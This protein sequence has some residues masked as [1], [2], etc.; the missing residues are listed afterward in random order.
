M[1]VCHGGI[2]HWLDQGDGIDLWGC[3]MGVRDWIGAMELISGGVP[4]ELY[5]SWIWAVGLI[6]GACD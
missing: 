3:V 2:R 5:T 4:G 6:Y 1:G